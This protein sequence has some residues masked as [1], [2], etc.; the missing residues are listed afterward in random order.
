MP[1]RFNFNEKIRQIGF[2][3]VL[4]F[5]TCLIVRELRYFASSVLGGFTIYMILR[6]PHRYLR[7]RGWSNG[8]VTAF[9]MI[10]SFI[11]LVLA[12]G[13]LT[14]MIYEKIK[15]FQP[16]LILDGLR[17]IHDTLIQRWDYD[18]F[19]QDL[20]QKALSTFGNSLPG[21]VSAMGSILANAAML[22]CVLFFLLLQR[23][24]FERG[25]EKFIPL[26]PG[27]IRMLKRSAHSMII[28]NVVGISVI[29]F[30]QALLAGLGYWALGVGE[31]VIWGLLT[32]FFGLI[33]VVGTAT[34][35]LPLSIEL[36]IS[37]HLWQGI[38]LAVYGSCVVA[39]VDNVVRMVFLKKTV[40]V[41]PLITLF[42]VILGLNLFGFWGIIFG[43]LMLSSFFLLIRI[44]NREFS[45]RAAAKPTPRLK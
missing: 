26:S 23:A 40:N 11:F 20:I 24:Q 3:L 21:L 25:V 37:G 44:Y 8:L 31:P 19:S 43:P 17:H 39:S 1:E 2:L 33:P 13:G 15:L 38:L 30:G 10:V 34:I 35:W 32:G 22:M 29:L 42:G 18:I 12:V 41:H 36:L 28:S 14:I 27:S 9:L 5:L 7:N 4:F 16:Q 6:R 45:I